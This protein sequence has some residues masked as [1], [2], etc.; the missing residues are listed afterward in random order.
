MLGERE[1]EGII[2]EAVAVISRAHDATYAS[3]VFESSAVLKCVKIG[4]N[5]EMF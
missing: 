3:M 2:I 4:V 1:G 5:L